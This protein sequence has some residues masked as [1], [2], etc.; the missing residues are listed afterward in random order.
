MHPST[1]W[2]T[3]NVFKL[4]EIN[5]L[6]YNRAMTMD[7]CIKALERSSLPTFPN[8]SKNLNLISEKNKKKKIKKQKFKSI[9]IYKKV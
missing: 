7:E 1:S 6:D 4:I 8:S 9:F 2:E 3:Y 5:G